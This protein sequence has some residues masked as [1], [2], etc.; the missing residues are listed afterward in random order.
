M[1]ETPFDDPVVAALYDP[2]D[3]DRSDLDA[4]VAIVEEL[5]ARSVLDV[6]C[7]TGSLALMLAARGLD[8]VGVDPAGAMLDVARAKPGA[9][10]VTWWHGDAET[11]PPLQADVATMTGNVAQVFLTDDAWLRTL[12]GIRGA[13]RP[14]G[15]LVFESREP[16]ARAWERWDRAST[17]S[18]TEVAGVGTVESWVEVV[19]VD[20]PLVTYRDTMLLPDGQRIDSDD[21]LRFRTRAELVASLADA[22]FTVAEVR[23]APDRPGLELVLIAGRD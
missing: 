17:W 20:G 10:A 14:G 18:S 9:D 21:T 11:L 3:D 23:D 19:A 15:W 22:G 8:V 5:G 7:G 1:A 13:L 6:G 16:S 4:Y 2:L 12:R